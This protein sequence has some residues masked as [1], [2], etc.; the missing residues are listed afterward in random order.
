MALF[1]TGEASTFHTQIQL[2]DQNEAIEGTL[3]GVDNRALKLL[4]DRTR[5]LYNN[6][7]SSAGSG[8]A[9]SG[10]TSLTINSSGSFT[11]LSGTINISS[12]TATTINA[13]NSTISGKVNFTGQVNAPGMVP[14]GSIIG[15]HP[16][17][18]EESL[19]TKTIDPN[20]W[21]LCDDSDNVLITFSNGDTDNSIAN[22][23][24]TDN[25]F[26]MGGEEEAASESGG[27]TDNEI[28]FA[29]THIQS[30]HK[31]AIGALTVED[32]TTDII[33]TATDGNHQHSFL[34]NVNSDTKSGG[35]NF[36]HMA[37]FPQVQVS[38][39]NDGNHKHTIVDPGHDHELSGNI[40][41][42]ALDISGGTTATGSGLTSTDIRPL[43]FKV[44]Y[45]MRIK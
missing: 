44:V 38:T 20:Y 10:I 32:G 33:D 24:L 14:L 1:Y 11:L 4:T 19:L 13:D 23:D 3:S 37:Y 40:G 43:Y 28:P 9:V 18:T 27:A 6:K 41:T 30:N 22:F 16:S 5:W 34:N 36:G 39:D 15:L 42:G 7:L 35:S 31:H 21:T 17:I 12:P 2:I 8:V 26:L 25:R 29:H 45:Y